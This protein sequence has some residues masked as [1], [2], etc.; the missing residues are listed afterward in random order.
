MG[1]GSMGAINKLC[2]L[3]ELSGNS[4]AS[5]SPPVQGKSGSRTVSLRS[6]QWHFE[7]H[8]FE[9]DP[10]P[11]SSIHWPFLLNSTNAPP[12]AP[13]PPPAI[14]GATNQSPHIWQGR[15]GSVLSHWDYRITLMIFF[16]APSLTLPS[17]TGKQNGII[18]S[19]PVSLP[20]Q[21]SKARDFRRP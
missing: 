3:A 12:P 11:H 13:P 20:F 4:M 10:P 8:I 2:D 19:I 17:G 1:R 5:V 6:H 21:D 9:W 7:Q 18:S 14:I 16:P 15:G